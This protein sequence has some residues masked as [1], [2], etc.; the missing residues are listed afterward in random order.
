MV[1]GVVFDGDIAILSS[2]VLAAVT[3]HF[4]DMGIMFN[5]DA[6][7]E[8]ASSSMNLISKAAYFFGAEVFPDRSVG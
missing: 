1:D 2:V 8:E 5:Q 3:S 7:I 6:F 4:R